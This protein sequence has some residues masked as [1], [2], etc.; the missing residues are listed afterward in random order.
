MILYRTQVNLSY[1][2]TLLNLLLAPVNVSL[3]IQNPPWIVH[4][5]NCNE[6]IT[7]LIKPFSHT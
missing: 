1:I 5:I 3:Q 7:N 4:N 6:I 2:F